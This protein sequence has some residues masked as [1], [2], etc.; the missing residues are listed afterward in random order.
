MYAEAPQ[1]SL[2]PVSCQS[3]SVPASP[4]DH[5]VPC[6][7]KASLDSYC[8]STHRLP[9]VWTVSLYLKH[10]FL[11][12]CALLQWPQFGYNSFHL[13]TIFHS[14]RRL[15]DQHTSS[16][17]LLPCFSLSSSCY[18]NSAPPHPYSRAPL[19]LLHSASCS[20]T[21]SSGICPYCRT[22]CLPA[23]AL[24]VYSSAVCAVLSVWMC[25]ALS[26]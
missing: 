10:S 17:S 20:R 1:P 9:S 14:N 23:L 11:S 12:L 24:R 5:S 13:I 21:I 4:P 3:C 6:L 22:R 19:P 16:A 18:L 15:D 26:M 25:A 7:H 2:S 8:H